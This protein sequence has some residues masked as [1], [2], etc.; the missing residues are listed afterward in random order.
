M[1]KDIE[2][3]FT[4]TAALLSKFYLEQKNKVKTRKQQAAKEM[5]QEISQFIIQTNKR[6][7]EFKIK[8]LKAYLM[9]SID[10]NEHK[11]K[12]IIN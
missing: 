5:F 9:K 3:Q 11:L 10:V 8:D 1:E 7:T 12:K 6:N 4:E 2:K